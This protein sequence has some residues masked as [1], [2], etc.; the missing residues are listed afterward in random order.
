[1]KD[2]HQLGPWVASCHWR[3]VCRSAWWQVGRGF[4][5]HV[6]QKRGRADGVRGW[7]KKSGERN[8]TE[9]EATQSREQSSSR[10]THLGHK[11]VHRLLGLALEPL[12]ALAGSGLHIC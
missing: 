6:C 12:E 5:L 11:V 2:S 4:E 3:W 8:S 7:F 10:N 1:M 9:G